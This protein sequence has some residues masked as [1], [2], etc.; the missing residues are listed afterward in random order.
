MQSRKKSS[1][2]EKRKRNEKHSNPRNARPPS[3]R[4]VAGKIQKTLHWENTKTLHNS[5]KLIYCDSTLYEKFH[6]SLG[7][8]KIIP[9][10]S[11]FQICKVMRAYVFFLHIDSSSEMADKEADWLNMARISN[12][13]PKRSVYSTEKEEECRK[14]STGH[15]FCAC[16]IKNGLKNGERER[17]GGREGWNKKRIQWCARANF[18]YFL[19][20]LHID[21][22]TEMANKEADCLNIARISNPIPKRSVYSTE[23]KEECR[24]VQK[25][26]YVPVR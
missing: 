19:F 14:G 6:W 13:I 23:K 9:C 5:M 2:S 4:R 1:S 20:F 10:F 26:L 3:L 15:T 16:L 22:S 21:S 17:R 12:P 7:Q 8:R 18:F 25:L 24:G 11:S